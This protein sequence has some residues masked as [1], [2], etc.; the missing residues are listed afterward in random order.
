M[1]KLNK[2]RV[3]SGD[4]IIEVLFA[5]TVFSLVA[6]GAMAIMNQGSSASQRALEISIVRQEVDAQAEAL[7]FLNSSYLAAYQLGSNEPA[8]NTPAGQWAEMMDTVV[9]TGS[10]SASNFS[11]EGTECPSP[12]QGSFIINAKRAMFVEPSQGA[13]VPAQTFSQVRYDLVN[14]QSTV[15]AADG[16]WIEAVRS[17]TV[18]GNN[19]S[20]AGYI[21]FHI[22]ACWSTMGS[23]IPV[24]VGT[25]VRL[26][27]P[28]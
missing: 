28:R 11:V 26:Y 16:I 2:K 10:T 15:V 12:P 23:A 25:I 3:Q 14:G 21:D 22:R 1:L 24:L 9:S 18:E 20:D 4:T 27:E 8:A 7:R 6:V 19:Q 13:I 17:R 5:I